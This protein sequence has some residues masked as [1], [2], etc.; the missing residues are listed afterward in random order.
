MSCKFLKLSVDSRTGSIFHQRLLLL[1]GILLGV[2]HAHVD[3]DG[4]DPRDTVADTNRVSAY[5]VTVC[6]D[7]FSEFQQGFLGMDK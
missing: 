4:V 5:S 6:L 3:V 1:L 2:D 7:L